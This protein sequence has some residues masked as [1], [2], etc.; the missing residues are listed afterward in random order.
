VAL[1]FSIKII[2][3][4]ER[5]LISLLKKKDREAFKIIV[6]TWQGMVYNTALGILQ[7]EE[8]AE[9]ISQEVFIQVYESISSF[10]EESKFSTWLYRITIS[11]A[12]DHIRK[13]KRKKRFAFIQSLYGKDNEVKIDPPDFFHPGVNLENKE[14]AAI[15]FKAIEKLSENQ[16]TAFVLSRI[17][18]LSYN[19]IGE[20]M[21]ISGSAVDALLQRAKKNL[22]TNLKS[23]Y[24]LH[25]A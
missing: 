14:N 13:K 4:N 16:K 15:L 2:E 17:E 3:L 11:K 22:Q 24:Q 20:I 18:G 21:A 6:E 10:K 7:S 5:E 8:D 19:D 9:D 25:E 12:M 23:Y 1:L